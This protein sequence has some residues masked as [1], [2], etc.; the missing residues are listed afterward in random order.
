M[1]KRQSFGRMRRA[2]RAR[3]MRMCGAWAYIE[4]RVV[5]IRFRHVEGPLPFTPSG[6]PIGA[7]RVAL[8][9]L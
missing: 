3:M 8:P 1:R 2:L 7:V 5:R 4:G 6:V 9:A